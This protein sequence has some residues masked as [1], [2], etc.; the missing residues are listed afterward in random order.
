MEELNHNKVPWVASVHPTNLF[1]LTKNTYVKKII[2]SHRDP[3]FSSLH[4]FHVYVF[5][6]GFLYLKP[7]HKTPNHSS[8]AFAQLNWEKPFGIIKDGNEK[9]SLLMVSVSWENLLSMLDCAI[10]SPCHAW[11]PKGKNSAQ[12]PVLLAW[13]CYVQFTRMDIWLV[14]S[15][16]L[17]NISQIGSS[18]Q[19]NRGSHK[20]P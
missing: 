19:Q 7:R 16:P 5:L 2:W 10:T 17:K 20:I 13:S 8:A 12:Y 14:V 1:N 9:N 6:W 4:N 3:C 15:N 18:S 11:L